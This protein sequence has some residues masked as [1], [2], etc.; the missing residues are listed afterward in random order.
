MINNSLFT[1]NDVFLVIT[2]IKVI[3]VGVG[4]HMANREKG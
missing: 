2:L 4:D 3:N 1:F